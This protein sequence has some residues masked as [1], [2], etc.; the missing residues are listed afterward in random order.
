[1]IP[2]EWFTPAEREVWIRRQAGM[3]NPQI[4]DELGQSVKAVAVL[5]SYAKSRWERGGPQ[6]TGNCGRE[7]LADRLKMDAVLGQQRACQTCGLRGDHECLGASG[8]DRR[9]SWMSTGCV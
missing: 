7:A 2:L 6:A 5:Y 3:K 9:P 4:A 8:W 1:M